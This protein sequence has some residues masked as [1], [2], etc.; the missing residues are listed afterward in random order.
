MGPAQ[1]NAA[2]R[3]R[4]PGMVYRVFI[5]SDGRHLLT[6]NSNGTVYVLRLAPR[7]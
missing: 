5:T 4:L 3:W 2:R 7:R 1:A 6:H